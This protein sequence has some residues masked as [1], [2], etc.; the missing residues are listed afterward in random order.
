MSSSG[1]LFNMAAEDIIPTRL[2]HAEKIIGRFDEV[3]G[4]LSAFISGSI[5]AAGVDAVLDVRDREVDSETNGCEQI[6]AIKFGEDVALEIDVWLYLNS[7]YEKIAEQESAGQSVDVSDAVDRSLF[8]GPFERRTGE[9]PDFPPEFLFP[10][11]QAD[12]TEERPDRDDYELFDKAD[13][14]DFLTGIGRAIAHYKTFVPKPT[15]GPQ[16]K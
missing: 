7:V 14:Q 5:A 9:R 1:K 11:L 16:P 3:I 12:E 10:R 13:Q 4:E 6:V 2:K 8:A 15:Q